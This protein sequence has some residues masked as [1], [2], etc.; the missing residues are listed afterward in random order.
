MKN[1]THQS[2]EVLSEVF[3]SMKN[4]KKN[5][6]KS[7]KELSTANGFYTTGDLWFCCL[8]VSLLSATIGI[9]IGAAQ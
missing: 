9:I 8:A 3:T 4:I 1:T 5:R 2:D 6:L 7:E